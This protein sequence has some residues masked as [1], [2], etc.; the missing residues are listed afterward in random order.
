MTIIADFPFFPLSFDNDGK[1][2]DATQLAALQKQIES[3]A[4]TDVVFISH[5]FR[6]SEA[7][8]TN[9]YT[10]FLTNLRAH[11]ASAEF[12]SLAPRKFGVAGVM[13]PSKSFKEAS[14]SVEGHAQSIG[15]TSSGRDE[16]MAAMKDARDTMATPAQKQKLDKAIGMLDQLE[17]NPAIHDEFV[18]LVLSLTDGVKLE[19]SE[20]LDQLRAKD[21]ADVLEI[22]KAPVIL[23]TTSDDGD[24]GGVA[25]FAPAA[26]VDDDG[27][28]Q[29][30]GSFFGSVF[31]AVGT[32]MNV[33]TWYVMKNRSGVVGANGVAEAVRSIKALPNAPRVHLVGHSLGGRL[34]ASC[35]KTLA[36]PPL[37]QPDSLTLLEAAFSHYGFSAKGPSNPEGFFRAVVAN[38]VVKGPIVA[39]YSSKDIVVGLTY[40]VASRLANDNTKAVG[41]ANDQFGGIGRNGVQNCDVGVLDTLHAS[42][43]PYADIP[44]GKV[45]C[46]DGSAGLINNHSDITNP[47]VTYLFASALTRTS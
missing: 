3:D 40:A 17:A 19:P 37:L 6:N 20:G 47:A 23:P 46:F 8:A 30:L 5:G 22:L 14:D 9:L 13:W 36:S 34:M 39:T 2:T 32:L 42:D 16:A 27:S 31:G 44:L 33:T 18:K 4:L 21:G 41:D 15:D 11:L 10:Q 43:V 28:T 29:G 12:T 26:P 38:K 24:G 7:D 25:S 1:L 35:S 45:V